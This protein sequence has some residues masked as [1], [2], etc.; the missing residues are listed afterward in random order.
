VTILVIVPVILDDKL[1]RLQLL[2]RALGRR[3]RYG[4]KTWGF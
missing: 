1:L 3:E 4:V 2:K